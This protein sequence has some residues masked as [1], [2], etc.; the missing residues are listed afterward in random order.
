[1]QTLISE[2]DK[3]HGQV[4]QQRKEIVNKIDALIGELNNS[5]QNIIKQ[6]ST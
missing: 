5:K 1:M 3:T 4:S 2:L 6:V